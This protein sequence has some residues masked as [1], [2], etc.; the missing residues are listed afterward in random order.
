MSEPGVQKMTQ[1]AISEQPLKAQEKR[2]VEEVYERL[3]V[4]EQECRAYHDAAKVV[5]EIIRLRD[6]YQDPAGSKEHT[7]QLQTLKSTFN[8]CVADQMQNMPEARVLPETPEH[9]ETADDLQDA[10]HYIVYNMNNY[11]AVHRRRAEDFY[12]PGTSITQVTWDE[13]MNYGKGDIALIRWP[14]ESFLWD[15]RAEDIQDARAL[16]KVSWHP[17]SWYAAHYPDL[18]QYIN[19]EDGMYN[20]VG[21]PETQRTQTGSDEPRAMLLEYWYRL[22][23]AK[24]KRYSI[25]VAY[26]AGGAMLEH[27][28]NVFMHGMYPFIV[29]VHST[30]EGS[31]AGEGLVSEL[32]PM[33]RYINRY[34]RYIDMNLR[35]ASKGRLLTR[36]GAGIDKTALADWS[37]DLVEGDRI[38]QGEDW[39]WLQHQPFNGMIAQQML[40]MQSDLK[41]DS[42]ANQYTRGET[43]AG[44]TAAKAIA[45]LQE[46]G[47]KITGL[48]TDTL[49][50]GF[51]LI[52]EQ[53]LW[54]MSE[55]YTDER[56]TMITGKDGKTKQ[57]T[58]SSERFFGNAHKKSEGAAP[59]PPYMV[60]VEINKRNPLRV[61]AQ[62][63]MY[64]QAYTMAA[65]AKQYFPLS[66]LFR[67]MNIDGK[68]RLLPVIEENERFMQQMEQLQQQN[69]QMVEQMSAMQAENDRLKMTTSQTINALANVGATQGGGY[70]PQQQGTRAPVPG[71]PRA[72]VKSDAVPK[73][74]TAGGGQDTKAA[75]VN[76]ARKNMA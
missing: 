65:Q 57:I 26:C 39:G 34:A 59:P 46:A 75:L 21:V 10:V 66:A 5:R 63:E 31:P 9:Q 16:I 52:V 32:A 36:R 35:M 49:N 42:G 41:Q 72:P 2:L 38:T 33:M 30:I 64:M 37:Q 55:F 3:Q 22:Y 70:L 68:D 18:A 14:I 51:K 58:M 28:E 15:P 62:N 8:N 6:P 24:K 73:V 54:L 20:E 29:D 40:Q 76:Q 61:E 67:M 11:P 53:V 12:G 43:A 50:Y 4:F 60:Q 13:S 71:E 27:Q 47:G 48:R 56:M 19:A 44:V 45:A 25:N 23:D 74:A 7:L 17:M 1:A 69:A